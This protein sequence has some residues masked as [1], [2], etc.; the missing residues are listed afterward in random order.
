MNKIAFD[1]QTYTE[2]REGLKKLMGGGKVLLLGNQESSMNFGHNWYP[3]RQDSTFLYY[4]G[5]DQPDLAAIIDCD[6][7]QDILF[8]D[9]LTMD[10]IIWTGELPSL[11]SQAEQ[12][13]LA[14]VEA[15]AQLINHIDA[16]IHFLPPYRPEHSV[17]IGK[18]LGK[19][20]HKVTKRSSVQ[21]IKAVCAQR[22]IKSAAEI[23]EMHKAASITHEMHHAVMSAARPGMKGHELVAVAAGVAH[24][25]NVL[26]S[27]P[28]ILTTQGQVLHNHDY[29]SVL[30]SGDIVLYDGGCEAPSHYAGD[31][32]RVFPV[33]AQYTEQ[34]RS[35][36]S[37]VLSALEQSADMA[38]A[39]V[40]NLDVHKCA[41]RVI[42]QGLMDLGLM[43]GD[44]EEA[45]CLGAHT[46]FFQHGVGHMLGLDV[47]DME[48][49][50]EEH[51]GYDHDHQRSTEFGWRSLRM[52][53]ELKEGFAITIEPGIYFIPQLIDQRRAEGAYADFI[54]YEE[55]ER[56]KDFGGIRIE[57]DYIIRAD[58]AEMLGSGVARSIADVEAV[59]SGQ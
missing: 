2:R 3:F 39:G 7:G 36:Y 18:L 29:T 4:F 44:V 16:G 21:L 34:Q 51:I 30:Q 46:L 12:V 9:E 15:F 26:F 19:K 52:G 35:I 10:D 27:F 1:K 43:R 48:N 31:I 49:F 57:D 33:D 11:Q 53:K 38:R 14:R 22:E 59:R 42:T 54:N 50:G 6:G 56:W 25:H 45:M 55:V 20:P 23:A 47:H 40:T 41:C 32:T 13:G 58:H 24:R 17:L 28:P 5:I 37:I 8:G